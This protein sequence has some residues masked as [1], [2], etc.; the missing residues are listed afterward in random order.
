MANDQD[1]FKLGWACVGVFQ[2]L[3]RKLKGRQLDGPTQSVFDV[4][5]DL[6][7]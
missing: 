1:Y 2:V 3:R 5:G 6:T 7:T 4:I